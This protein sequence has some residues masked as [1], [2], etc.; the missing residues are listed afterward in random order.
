[1]TFFLGGCLPTLKTP[2]SETSEA[3]KDRAEELEAEIV[4]ELC[5]KAWLPTD[6]SS[7]DTEKTQLGNRANNAARE[8]YCRPRAED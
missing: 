8:A 7:R 2:I 1:M 6:Y 4:R 5:T 3:T